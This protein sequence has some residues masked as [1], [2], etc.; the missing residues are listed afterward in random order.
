MH[1]QNSSND[2]KQINWPEM[3]ALYQK[4]GLQQKAF[5]RWQGITFPSFKYHWSRLNQSRKSTKT[6]TPLK[7]PKNFAPIKLTTQSKVT[8]KPLTSYTITL[9]NGFR[10]DVTPG[11]DYQEVYRLMEVLCRC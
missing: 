9:P 6:N 5:C 1:D 4:S 11:C 8:Q 2:T 3:L 10:L 7:V